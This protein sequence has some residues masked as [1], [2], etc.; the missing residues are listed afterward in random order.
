M[1]IQLIKMAKD[2][3]KILPELFC[4][5]QGCVQKMSL[6]VTSKSGKREVKKSND[7]LVDDA[8]DFGK[9]KRQL[10]S[11]KESSIKVG[12][13]S[14]RKTNQ[15]VPSTTKGSNYTDTTKSLLSAKRPLKKK[16]R[17]LSPIKPPANSA[18]ST[19]QG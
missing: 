12:T 18:A 16:S 13:S 3:A 1:S 4:F 5:L 6:C 11:K 8:A 9:F 2:L 15:A 17:S 10:S 7:T 14:K 19:H